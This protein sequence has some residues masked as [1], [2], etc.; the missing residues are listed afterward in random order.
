MRAKLA[1]LTL[2]VLPHL[3]GSVGCTGPRKKYIVLAQMG[4]SCSVVRVE[5][6]QASRPD[7]LECPKEDEIET[8]WQDEQSDGE[9]RTRNKSFE[10]LG[11]V[12]RS[13]NPGNRIREERA[14]TH[15]ISPGA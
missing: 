5:H 15:G 9:D 12:P 3:L 13:P 11:I 1:L 14:D 6:P 10:V 4:S 8:E 2:D 7:A